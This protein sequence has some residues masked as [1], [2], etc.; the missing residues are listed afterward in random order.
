MQAS[1]V[2]LLYSLSQEA[3][4]AGLYQN[5]EETERMQMNQCKMRRTDSQGDCDGL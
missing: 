4:E 2:H 1:K 5:K 3:T